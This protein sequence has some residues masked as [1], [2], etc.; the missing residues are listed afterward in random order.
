VENFHCVWDF[1]IGLI[2]YC[3]SNFGKWLPIFHEQIVAHL[4]ERS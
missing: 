4:Q 2:H 3:S 1:C